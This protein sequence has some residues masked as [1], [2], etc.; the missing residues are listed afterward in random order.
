[1]GSDSQLP[2]ISFPTLTP[3]VIDIAPG[4]KQ[5][6]RVVNACAD[7]ILDLQVLFDKAPQKIQLVALDGVPVGSQDGTA[8]GKLISVKDLRLPPASRMEFIVTGPSKKVKNAQFI[9]Q[10][11]NTGPDGDNDTQRTLANIVPVSGPAGF[12]AKAN[13]KVMTP[14]RQRFEGLAAARVNTK[15]QL[16][17]SENADQTQFFITVNGQTPVVFSPDNPPAV[18]TTQGSVEDWTIQNRSRRTMNSTSIKFIS[19]CCRRTISRLTAA[20]R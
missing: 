17:F 20:S 10:A 2:P 19:W 14:W 13:P 16:F 1:M 8:R 4:E 15:R 11:I 9:T 3:A 7:T 6:W 12:S 18:T 5:F